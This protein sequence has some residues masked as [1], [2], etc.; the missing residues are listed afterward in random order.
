MKL[1][2]KIFKF[3][4]SLKLAVI[5]VVS[6]GV[7]SAWGTIVESRYDMITAQKLVYHSWYMYSVLFL[8]I[9]NLIAVMVD[10]LPW[11]KKHIGFILA[12]VGIIIL[13]VGSY[14]TRVVGIDG[15]L[16]FDIGESQRYISLIDQ[17]EV[18]VYQM[19]NFEDSEKIYQE[20]VDFLVNPPKKNPLLIPIE[21]GQ[22]EIFDYMPYAQKSF[23]IIESD[24]MMDG[25]ALRFQLTNQFVNMTEWIVQMGTQPAKLSLGPAQVVLSRDANYQTLGGMNEI[26]LWP[27]SK[28]KK[29]NYKIYNKDG[30]VQREGT[31]GF[32]EEIDTGW[33]GL[34]FRTVQ[35]FPK[36]KVQYEYKQ[37]ERPNA[38]SVSAARFRFNGQ[39]YWLGLN[40]ALELYGDDVVYF[41]TYGNKRIDLGFPVT[42]D[43]FEM[44][45]YQG[46]E[47][48]ASYKS[49]VT[50]P[51]LGV[52]EISMNEPLKYKGFT[53]YQASF[54]QDKMGQ[55]IG[56]V[57]SV[58][59]DP[60]RFWKYLGSL[61]IVLGSIVLFY[62]KRT[63][64][65]EN[66]AHDVT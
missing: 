34:K 10:R 1:F 29:L 26:V 12:H 66:V 59:R 63:R 50:V 54:Q 3:L 39:E 23:Q 40:T 24:K 19:K 55:P 7:I 21:K 48:A 25:P 16:V 38:N 8:L 37:L 58:N 56:S 35:Y 20:K 30:L 45:K 42:L 15:T 4:A 33:M 49:I 18:V 32:S 61:M 17:N 5:I 9:V 6:L 44:E 13:L 65:K 62:F 57:L 36:S 22:I 11:Q 52:Q 53:F 43:R 47:M 2:E 60:G 41:I 28:L 46:T 31:I 64:K 27:H 14:V 51:E